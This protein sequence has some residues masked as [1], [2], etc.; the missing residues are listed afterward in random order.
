MLRLTQERVADLAGERVHF[1]QHD[2]LTFSYP[3]QH[4]DLI[5]TLFFLDV[6]RRRRSR[7]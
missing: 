6:L 7:G 2:A 4:Y 1:Y 5:V 3:A